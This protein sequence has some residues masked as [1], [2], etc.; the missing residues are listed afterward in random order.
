MRC[1]FVPSTL[2]GNG[3][4][5]VA[6]SFYYAKKLIA[7]SKKHD[8]ALYIPDR[9]AAYRSAD[10]I[11]LAFIRY[12]ELVPIL[13]KIEPGDRW[14]FIIVDNRFTTIHELRL[15][16]QHGNVICIDESG[17]ARSFCAYC[18]DMLHIPPA[19]LRSLIIPE[20]ESANIEDIGFLPIDVRKQNV[21]QKIS[22]ILIAFGGED[23]ANLTEYCLKKIK[24]KCFLSSIKITVLTGAFK[25]FTNQHDYPGIEFLSSIPDLR[26]HIHEYDCVI[27][28]YGITAYEARMAGCAVLLMHPS[29]E[30]AR[31]A[32]AR[33][34]LS[35][36][37]VF[38]STRTIH[39]FI[40]NTRAFVSNTYTSI[41]PRDIAKLLESLHWQHSAFCMAC[42]SYSCHAVYRDRKKTYFVCEQCGLI[43][44]SYFDEQIIKYSDRAYFFEEYKEQYGKT[45]LEDMD[46]L[47]KFARTRLDI[48]EKLLPNKG[49]ILDIGC[50]Y[51]AF[52][53]EAQDSGWKP[54]GL[55]I[56]QSATDYVKETWKIPALCTDFAAEHLDGFIP[57]GNDCITLWYVI[58][59]FET[60]GLVLSRINQ[61]LRVGG[62][63]AFST[64]S[65]NG[66]S[67]RYNKRNFYKNSPDDHWTIWNPRT[68][69][70]ILSRYGFAV[71]FVRVTGHHPERFPFF[72]AKPGSI[73]FKSLRTISKLFGLGDTFECYAV[74]VRNL[75]LPFTM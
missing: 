35:F 38:S 23:A 57:Q 45:Y 8:A 40:Q 65:G 74:K 37:S 21:P 71:K 3:T 54:V 24:A 17:P 63:L 1:L 19:K 68:V 6:R 59:H 48:I 11:R 4:G 51:G 53:K 30:H 66:V 46:N 15:L 32:K 34:F 29:K 41:E 10:E 55:D 73:I 7:E 62:I 60:L 75:D 36:T 31:L 22:N 52:V 44:L 28:H 72:K 42:G 2:I 43:R 14:D 9:G 61:L 12:A 47:R 16:E 67:A 64:P 69:Q 27:T 18:I 33:G 39:K 70:N 5:H 20:T 25:K 56:S 49:K 26:D 50:A 13:S 58:E